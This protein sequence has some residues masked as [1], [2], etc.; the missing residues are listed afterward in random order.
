M[1]DLVLMTF[2]RKEYPLL[3]AFRVMDGFEDRC[4]ALTGH[5]ISLTNGTATLR[6]RAT[7]VFLAMK[8]AREDEGGA[9][10]DMSIQNTMQAM[11]EAGAAD[12]DLML[13][14]VELIER[15]LY[16]PDQYKAKKEARERAEADQKEIE[17]LL[18]ASSAYSDSPPQFLD[19]NHPSFGDPPPES[20]FQP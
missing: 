11:W 6:A 18:N 19:G 7:L 15:L 1:R 14:E 2:G 4:G 16:T 8:A 17:R 10:A 13:K 9:T 3:P 12:N 20:S 5:L